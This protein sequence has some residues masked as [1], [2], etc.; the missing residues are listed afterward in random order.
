MVDKPCDYEVIV[1]YLNDENINVL[2]NSKNKNEKYSHSDT[3]G[4]FCTLRRRTLK[5]ISFMIKKEKK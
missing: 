3:A 5:H 2:N 1:I 4:R